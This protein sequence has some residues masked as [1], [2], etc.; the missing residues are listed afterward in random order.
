MQCP[1]DAIHTF[2]VRTLHSLGYRTRV[3]LANKSHLL[4]PRRTDY[5]VDVSVYDRGSPRA[6]FAEAIGHLAADRRLVIDCSTYAPGDRDAV[7]VFHL[8]PERYAGMAA[9][10]VSREDLMAL[11]SIQDHYV[12]YYRD[13]GCSAGVLY[14]TG[15]FNHPK[16]SP[17]STTLVQAPKYYASKTI[18]TV[19]SLVNACAD[20]AYDRVARVRCALVGPGGLRATWSDEVAPFVPKSIS[21]RDEL[22]KRGV[23][24]GD[25][26]RFVC[27][28]ALCENATVVPLTILSNSQSG[29]LG[30]EHSLSP[31]YYAETMRGPARARMLE[32]LSAS[33]LFE[34]AR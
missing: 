13:D 6:R 10:E 11:A 30:I 28:Y 9:V 18:D 7:L 27:L 26:P 4:G 34:V 20:P 25:E 2:Q 12:E 31:D 5:R 3:A 15:P 17:K 19:L 22:V 33:S 14:Q 32:R 21:V 24:I 1:V 16:L 29:A 8:V 23:E